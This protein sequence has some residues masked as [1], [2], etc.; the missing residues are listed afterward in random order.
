MAPRKFFVGGNW[1][2]NGDKK[3]LGE[4]IQTLNAAKVNADTEVVCG[5]PFIYLEFARKQ[6]DSKFGVAAQ[7]CYK[8]SKGAFTGE[9]SPA[10]IKDCGVTWV[11]LGHS[12]R[13]HVFGE[14]DELIGQ[15]VS[16][17]LS[18]GLGVVACIGEKLDEREAGITEKVV[19]E[20]TKVIA[21]NVKDWSK[22]VLAYE[23]VWAIGTGKTATPQQAQE[24]HEKLRKWLKENVS[25]TVADSV[26]IIYGGSV[27]GASCK[28][29]GSQQD[30][31]G[32]LVGGA[33]LKPEFVTIINARQ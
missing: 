11:I 12:E 23:P 10:M 9:I 26:R 21:D 31:D 13:R 2:M 27:T 16:H 22:V 7:N 30:V 4:L 19:F 6:L 25:E 14:S 24:V 33:S 17:A 1:K 18:E 3:S 29:L 5:A 15:K 8:V 32:F 28:E 20:Q